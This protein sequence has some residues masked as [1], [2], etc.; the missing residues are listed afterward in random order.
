MTTTKAFVSHVWADKPLAV[1]LQERL[2]AYGI[3]AWVDARE[4]TGG[5]ALQPEIEKAIAESDA[6]LVIFSRETVN[7]TWVTKEIHHALQVQRNHREHYKI[8]P[9]LRDGI[10]P[11][12]L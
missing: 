10:K 8:I 1:E 3:D 11:A 7:S 4:L 6:F 5:S 2:S 12:A 9:L